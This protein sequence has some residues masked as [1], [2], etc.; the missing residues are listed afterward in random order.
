MGDRIL[1]GVRSVIE[2]AKISAWTPGAIL[3]GHHLERG[4]PSAL[5]PAD[6]SGL[7]HIVERGLGCGKFVG[8]KAS[9]L[10]EHRPACCG[11][12]QDDPV[13]CRWLREFGHEDVGVAGPYPLEDL[14]VRLL[15]VEKPGVR[16]LRVVGLSCPTT[17]L[18]RDA[19]AER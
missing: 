12:L 13:L 1:V 4:G 2:A 9:G 10:G 11:D 8:G 15:E 5:G 19:F 7:G 14:T 18:V 17:R 6:Y 3:L 16:R